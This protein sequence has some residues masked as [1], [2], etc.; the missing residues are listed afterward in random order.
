MGN[1]LVQ[2]EWSLN[3]TS[4]SVYGIARSVLQA[5]TSDNVQ[6]LAILA[7]EA[8]GN[9]LAMSRETCLKI[10]RS[11]LP[12][13]DPMPLRFLKVKIGFSKH[14]CAVHFGSNQA[15]IRFLG[16]AAA[17]VTTIKPFQGAQTLLPMLEATTSDKRLLPSTKQLSDL[18]SSLEG[19][20]QYSG[21]SDI[22]FGYLRI[23]KQAV[24]TERM[25]MENFRVPCPEALT[26][27]V[28]VLR[29]MQRMGADSISHVS[30]KVAVKYAPWV[31]AF[32]KWCLEIPPSLIINDKPLISQ[33]GSRLDMIVVYDE[34]EDEDQGIEITIHHKIN[35]LTD[36]FVLD[37]DESST[38]ELD[39]RVGFE[40]TCAFLRQGCGK[41]EWARRALFA[42]LPSTILRLREDLL[43]LFTE[44]QVPS[45]VA[46]ASQRLRGLS[47]PDPFPTHSE[48]VGLLSV[49]LGLDSTEL[50]YAA[51]PSTALED[52]PEVRDY[53]QKSED[54][55]H[56]QQPWGATFLEPLASAIS[57]DMDS[58][59]L[60]SLDSK[61]TELSFCV[62]L[63]SLFQNISNLHMRPWL[64]TPTKI[65]RQL[66]ERMLNRKA[67]LNIEEFLANAGGLVMA[68]SFGEFGRYV[69]WSY[70]GQTL[71]PTIY[72]QL[73]LEDTGYLGIASHRGHIIRDREK[74]SEVIAARPGPPGDSDHTLRGLLAIDPLSFQL[75]APA[76]MFSHF[77]VSWRLFVSKEYPAS[78]EAYLAF[79]K[80]SEGGNRRCAEERLFIGLCYCWFAYCDHHP[81]A[82]A[83][84]PIPGE[85]L[86]SP[87]YEHWSPQSDTPDHVRVIA[88]D[89]D[90]PKRLF[91]IGQLGYRRTPHVLRRRACLD[92]CIEL[93]HDTGR[94]VL[95]L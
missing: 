49:V 47:R 57:S 69:M 5:A 90:D 81:D 20:C 85:S 95:I 67:Y 23:M 51:S 91:A 88:V 70:K 35:N 45:R 2:A 54:Q 34:D 87:W 64:L 27:L 14:D 48:V 22:V 86:T 19:R 37:N 29:R 89:G 8:F 42:V 59:P 52:M 73:H 11:V 25:W 65:A 24:G 36:I 83:Q 28:D 10:E 7:C 17:L 39:S 3:Q 16:L 13:P 68:P 78:L 60:K 66:N 4:D 56:F 40:T 93:C 76:D 50:P 32:S 6:P 1:H 26:T 12:T 18:L 55:H 94:K 53:I 46:S 82:P 80:A 21:F 9:T 61:A 31:A 74:Y 43:G 72:E 15:G 62:L 77:G 63:L 92:C 84:H 41:S 30:I 58:V 71:W 79:E 44:D 75:S 33:T 38:W